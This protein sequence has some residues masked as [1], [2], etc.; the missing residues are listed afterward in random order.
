[1]EERTEGKHARGTNIIPFSMH[2]VDEMLGDIG[3]NVSGFKRF[4]QWLMPPSAKDYQV[5]TKRLLQ[6]QQSGAA[7]ARVGRL[8]PGD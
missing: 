6:R 8:Q 1:M 7:G 3:I 5:I 2:N 4:K